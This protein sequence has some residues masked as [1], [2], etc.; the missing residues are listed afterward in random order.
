MITEDDLRKLQPLRQIATGEPLTGFEISA[1][2]VKDSALME[3]ALLFLSGAP[4]SIRMENPTGWQRV[5]VFGKTIDPGRVA[6]AADGV[7]VIDGERIREQYLNAP[8]GAQVGWK[9]KC[10]GLCRFISIRKVE[11]EPLERYGRQ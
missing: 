8:E 1:S 5:T 7:T 4:T 3:N 11:G 6:I 10:N 9:G 2:L